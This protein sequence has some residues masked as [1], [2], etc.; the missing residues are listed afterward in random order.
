MSSIDLHYGRNKFSTIS[1]T[2]YRLPLPLVTVDTTTNVDIDGNILSFVSSIQLEGTIIGSG[3]SSLMTAYSG[4]QNFFTNNSNQGQNFSIFCNNTNISTYSGVYLKSI[5]AQKS[6]DNWTVLLPYSIT[7]ESAYPASGVIGLIQSFEDSWSIEPLE[8]ISYLNYVKDAV[9]KDFKA[10][11][12]NRDL[13]SPP[14]DSILTNKAISVQV[15]N[16]LQHRITHRVSA[17]GKSIDR[18]DLVNPSVII[19]KNPAYIEAARWVAD[20]LN[21]S[22]STTSISTPTGIAILSPSSPPTTGLHLYNHVRTIESNVSAGSYGIV[23]TWLALTSGIKYTEEFTWEISTDDKLIKTVTMNGTIKGLE[24]V[25]NNGFTMFPD[26]SMTGVIN[27][28]FPSKFPNQNQTNNKFT[29]AISGYNNHV[30]PYL[31]QR[32]SLALSAIPG[33]VKAS[34]S[35][36][37]SDQIFF[38]PSANNPLNVIPA[39]YSESM[40]PVA[41]TVGYSVVYSNR[42]GSFIRGSLSSSITVTDSAPSDQVAETFILGRPLG[43]ILEKVGTTKSERRVNVEILYP[44]PT[45]YVQAH[46][47]SP[48]CVVY[49]GN[50]SFKELQQLVN[51][52]RPIAAEAF[53][54]I[55]PTSSYSIANQGLVFKTNDSRNWNP[56]EGRFSWDITWVYNT[57]ECL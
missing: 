20:R 26:Q 52:F 32:A 9:L 1:G 21:K 57:G 37:T 49:S 43:P 39:Q 6:N 11:E 48:Q 3:I 23:D 2:A 7:L 12:A 41:G 22:Y 46:P 38:G 53:A 25:S 17:V 40:N 27:P 10:S 31:Y 4:I 33:G 54:S 51:S 16:I 30:K 34:S 13:N 45:G 5:N 44:A 28:N 55:V 15:E 35:S 8:E 42:P 50:A 29:V 24:E 56:F 19:N 18:S 36:N 14:G 47:Q